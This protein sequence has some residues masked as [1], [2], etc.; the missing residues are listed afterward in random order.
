MT[1]IKAAYSLFK[2]ECFNVSEVVV[3]I[4][5]TMS[6]LMMTEKERISPKLWTNY[7][8]LGPIFSELFSVRNAITTGFKYIRSYVLFSGLL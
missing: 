2:V 3:I 6:C 5:S 7:Y 8:I 1:E 4:C